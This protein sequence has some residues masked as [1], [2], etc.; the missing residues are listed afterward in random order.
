MQCRFAGS[1]KHPPNGIFAV[2]PPLKLIDARIDL[3]IDAV[4]DV[5]RS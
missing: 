4:T 2:L 3:I 1:P 5:F